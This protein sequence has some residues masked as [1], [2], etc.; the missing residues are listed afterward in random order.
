MP[1]IVQRVSKK[2]LDFQNQR[3]AY[4]LR[5]VHKKPYESIAAKVVNLQ[6]AHPSWGHVR[7]LCKSFSIRSAC[8]KYKYHKC[9]RTPWKLT[10]DV[11]KFILRRL[12]SDRMKTV[13]TS[14]SLAE[15]V[16]KEKGVILESSS[17]RKLLLKRGYRWLPRAMKRMYSPEQ[18]EVRLRFARAVVRLSK[19]ALRSKL[20]MAMDGVV[21]AM[22]PANATDRF[23]YCWDGFRFMWR[24]Q[25]EANAPPL[26]GAD[27]YAKQVPKARA[28]PLWG[29][30]SEGGFAAVLWHDAK[31]TDNEEWSQVVRSGGLSQAL[32]KINPGRRVAPWSVLCDNES[33]L[34]HPSCRRAYAAKNIQLWGVPPKSPDLN[35][36]EMFWGWVRRQLRLKD[37]EDLRMKRPTMSRVDY[38][39]RVQG[40]LRGATAQRMAKRFASTLR[41]TCK[42][43]IKN[44]GAAARN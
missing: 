33:F 29:G 35:P 42:R 8:R 44:M 37:L 39:R 40:L 12:L 1:C 7:D 15:A 31:K 24:R 43:V 2:S 19:A 3:K 16:A 30:I 13:V 5:S 17:I 38:R 14:T 22:P 32:R 4:L 36:V 28:L 18:K 41:M 23:N 10:R 34:R 25:G 20:C 11:Q 26:A 9:G 6:G 27:N 21:L